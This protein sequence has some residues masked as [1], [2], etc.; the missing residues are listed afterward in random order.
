MYSVYT[1]ILCVITIVI[2]YALVLHVSLSRG[3]GYG[4][5]EL[6]VRVDQHLC[7]GVTKGSEL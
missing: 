2:I 5:I 3:L 6:F 4:A 1:H 7:V